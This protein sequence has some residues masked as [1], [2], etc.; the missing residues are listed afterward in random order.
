MDQVEGISKLTL[1]ADGRANGL[2]AGGLRGLDLAR[3]RIDVDVDV[4]L[5]DDLCVLDARKAAL[6]GPQPHTA[7]GVEVA[8]VAGCTLQLLLRITP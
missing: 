8:I 4:V 2:L 3:G 7:L 5:L 1:L 6:E